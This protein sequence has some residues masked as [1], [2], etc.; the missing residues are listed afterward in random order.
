MSRCTLVKGL[1]SRSVWSPLA[2]LVSSPAMACPVCFASSDNRV[3]HAF[4][5]STVMLTLLPFSL[6]G[7][8][9]FYLYRWRQGKHTMSRRG[10]GRAKSFAQ[11]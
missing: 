10:V 4:Y 2:V 11:K 8:L 1:L 9:A 6:V 7:G 5:A 3:L